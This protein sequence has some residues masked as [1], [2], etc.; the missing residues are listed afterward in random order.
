M[1]YGWPVIVKMV[2]SIA[3]SSL[4]L[5]AGLR[6][7]PYSSHLSATVINLRQSSLKYFWSEV[8][9]RVRQFPKYREVALSKQNNTATGVARLKLREARGS[10]QIHLNW[11][12]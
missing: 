4:R 5:C 7:F 3:P 12:F 8:W 1:I 6:H 9:A 2:V 10:D 11:N